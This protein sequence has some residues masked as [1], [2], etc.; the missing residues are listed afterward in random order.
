MPVRC[1]LE[2]TGRDIDSPDQ[3]GFSLF[4]REGRLF[5]ETPAGFNS[6]EEVRTFLFLRYETLREALMLIDFPMGGRG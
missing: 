5:E 2:I 4:D 3:Y 6:E 1:R